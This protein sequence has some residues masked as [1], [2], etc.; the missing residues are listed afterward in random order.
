MK[1]TGYLVGTFFVALA[2][3]HAPSELSAQDM[4][5][6]KYDPRS[7]L[8]V[9]GH[10]ITHARF[11]FVDIHGHQ[12]ASRM[13]AEDVDRLVGEMDELNMAVM[14]N[15]S[16]GSGE[17]LVD[18]LELMAGAHP[19]RF[20]FFANVNF[21]GVGTPG[22]G[23]RAADQLERDVANGAAGLKIFKNLGFGAN[24]VNGERIPVD[25]ERIFP[26]WERA[27]QLGIPVLIHSADPAEFWSPVDEHNE[28]W[29][30]LKLRPR[31]VQ[32]E[33]SVPFEQIIEE[34]HSLF[35]A[36]PNTQFI[37]A[38]MGWLAQDLGRLGELLDEMP[39]MHLG[40]GAVIYEFGRQPRF[41]A[42]WLEKYQDRVLMGKDSYNQEEFYTYFRVYESEDDYFPYYRKYH[43]FWRMYGLGLPDEVLRKIYYENA[44]RLVPAIDRSLFPG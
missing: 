11:P 24:D 16:G 9:S 10:V 32:P 23:E 20:V 4:S 25:D 21:E 14:V 44:L 6:E 2:A 22:W 13:T 12:R 26:V 17:R 19:G 38:H 1:R 18:G 27:G 34:Q 43:A 37:A 30:E 41:A 8:V 15:L 39:N 29:L 28:R 40:M 31:R 7:T 36:H 35:R 33:G 42:K 3:L 5:V